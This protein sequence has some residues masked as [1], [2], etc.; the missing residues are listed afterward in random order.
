MTATEIQE[1]I[2]RFGDC[3]ASGDTY[4]GTVL[5]HKIID[6]LDEL[7][8]AARRSAVQGEP[9]SPINDREE[10]ARRQKEQVTR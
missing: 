8:S 5:R 3:R 1:L 2:C 7:E 4:K 9:P 6:A 10:A